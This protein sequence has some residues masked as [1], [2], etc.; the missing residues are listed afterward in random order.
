MDASHRRPLVAGNWKMHKT[1]S[2]ALAFVAALDAK[3]KEAPARAEV[4]VAP[5][6]T[7][8]A[9]VARALEGTGIEV[10]GQNCH[11]EAAGAFTGE[12]SAP[13]VAELGARYVIL[14]H[15]ERRQHFG[16]TD[17]TVNRR[18]KAVLASQLRPIVC[19]GETLAER[20]AGQTLDVV[21]RQVTG[22][23]NGLSEGALGELVVAYEP[24]WAIGTGRNATSGQ[25]QEAQAH[26]RELLTRLY[27]RQFAQGVR[28]L[29]GG[30]VKPDNAKELFSQ[31]DVDGGLVG[32][33]SLKVADFVAIVQGAG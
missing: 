29:Y 17:E 23:L 24:V 14:G 10:G 31:P 30:S 21:T 5:P 16:E 12:V 4:L 3:L 9:P 22:A 20:D 26:I 19:V 15:S 7:A 2:E 8:L 6:F 18:L 32:G 27:Q 33:A 1:V 25:A 13:M 11:W 28:I